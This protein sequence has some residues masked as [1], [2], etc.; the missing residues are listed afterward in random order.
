MESLYSRSVAGTL[1]TVVSLMTDRDCRRIVLEGMDRL[2]GTG[3]ENAQADYDRQVDELVD[4]GYVKFGNE[5]EIII[6]SRQT[7]LDYAESLKEE[8]R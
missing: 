2:W 7:L 8:S 6:E 1:A 5:G 4:A 3:P